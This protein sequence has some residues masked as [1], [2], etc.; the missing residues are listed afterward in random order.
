M[1]VVTKE[2]MVDL[3]KALMGKPAVHILNVVAVEPV[4]VAQAAVKA[5]TLAEAMAETQISQA[6]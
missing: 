6:E 5:L 3:G 2:Q 4:A 1:A